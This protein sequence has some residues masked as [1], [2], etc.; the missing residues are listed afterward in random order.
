MANDTNIRWMG[1]SDKFFADYMHI[2]DPFPKELVD[3]AKLLKS[4]DTPVDISNSREHNSYKGIQWRPDVGLLRN[5]DATSTM[6]GDAKADERSDESYVPPAE[7]KTGKYGNKTNLLPLNSNLAKSPHSTIPLTN[8]RET[9][10]RTHR[11]RTFMVFMNMHEV[12]FLYHDRCATIVSEAIKYGS[13]SQVLAEFLW[14]FARLPDEQQGIDKTVKTP[15]DEQRI[16]AM[17]ALS[18]WA[19]KKKRPVVILEVPTEDGKTRGFA[20]WGAIAQPKSL[21]GRATRAYPAY[22][23]EE[24]KVVFLKDTWL[25]AVDGMEKESDILKEL[26]AAGVRHVPKFQ[27]GN[28]IPGDYHSTV[29]QNDIDVSWRAGPL[30]DLATKFTTREQ[31]NINAEWDPKWTTVRPLQRT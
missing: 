23:L 22:D 19:P 16:A 2:E 25:A 20:V 8:D 13:N 11:T 24:K 3:R 14:R 21:T 5:D 1:P 12:R 28:D 26:N 29:T 7:K 18:R 15:T 17:T 30:A 10:A 31:Q 6:E 27:Y 4:T 9:P